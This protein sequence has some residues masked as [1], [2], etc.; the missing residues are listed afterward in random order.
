MDELED[1]SQLIIDSEDEK[2]R[3]L[4]EYTVKRKA[5]RNNL[6]TPVRKILIAGS[7]APSLS[8]F[9]VPTVLSRLRSP[10]L[11]PSRL[12]MPGLS[13]CPLM[14]GLLSCSPMLGLL[15][16]PLMPGLLSYPM[17]ASSSPLLPA[18]LSSLVPA[19]SSHSVIGPVLTRFISSALKTFK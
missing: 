14:P 17:L 13:S 8:C 19:R 12:P 10:T 18:S 15:F 7:A 9:S 11:L 2:A 6:Y 5:R 1:D 4:L 16:C 3:T